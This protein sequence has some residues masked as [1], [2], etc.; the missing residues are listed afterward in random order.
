M[1]AQLGAGTDR[2]LAALAGGGSAPKT[3]NGWLMTASDAHFL[4]SSYREMLLEHLFAGEVMRHLWLTKSGGLEVL[5]PQVDDSGYDIV[6]DAGGIVRH[7]QLKASFRGSKTS[8]FTISLLLGAK[9]SGC[10]VFIQFD[11]ETLALGPFWFFGGP[12]GE[13]LPDLSGFKVARHS[14]G[15]AQGVKA[16]RPNLR[17]VPL[18]RF[19][20]VVDIPELTVRLFGHGTV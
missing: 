6:F 10:V 14:K 17:T 5:K 3:L 2:R 19:D 1:A 8:S 9:P 16:F 20:K 4:K 13:P 15:N 7:V 11:P 12:P 18:T